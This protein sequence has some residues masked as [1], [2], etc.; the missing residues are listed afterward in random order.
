MKKD[1]TYTHGFTLTSIVVFIAIILL[2]GYC[3]KCKQSCDRE[4]VKLQELREN[5]IPNI[6]ID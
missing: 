6:Q 1:R 5:Q 4:L 2:V 3:I